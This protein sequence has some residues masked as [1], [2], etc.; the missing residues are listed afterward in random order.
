MTDD[1]KCWLEKNKVADDEVA[2]FRVEAEEQL[3]IS[4]AQAAPKADGR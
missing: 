4:K 1:E 3:K 2:R